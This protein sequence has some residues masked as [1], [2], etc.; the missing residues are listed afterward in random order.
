MCVILVLHLAIVDPDCS[1]HKMGEIGASVV[2]VIVVALSRGCR[3]LA[4]VR[5]DRLLTTLACGFS[6]L[7]HGC[8]HWRVSVCIC[9]YCPNW[10]CV[11]D[12]EVQ[13]FFSPCVGTSIAAPIASVVS[14]RRREGATEAHRGDGLVKDHA[15]DAVGEAS[16]SLRCGTVWH[17]L[18]RAKGRG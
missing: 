17:C 9:R 18:A 14:P 15:A 5:C 11:I 16:L 10:H 2:D 8:F 1:M 13:L 6:L 12:C 3:F 7:M 4:L